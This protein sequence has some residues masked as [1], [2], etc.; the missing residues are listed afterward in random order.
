MP[1]K[2]KYDWTQ[3]HLKIFIKATPE[4]VFKAWT[5]AATVSQWFTV[6]T[7][8]IP[9]RGG[10]IYFEWLAGDKWETTFTEFAK[11]RKIVFPFGKGGEMVAVTVRKQGKGTVCELHQYDMKDTPKI[12]WTMH[13]GCLGGWI[14]FLT[15]LKAYLEHKI[16]LRSLD[17]SMSYKDDFIN[18]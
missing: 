14:F 11:N 7:E 10:L 8:I 12:R 16:D 18:S 4:K 9:K 15:N 1:P 2:K 17:P 13:R 5:D 6:K 3:F